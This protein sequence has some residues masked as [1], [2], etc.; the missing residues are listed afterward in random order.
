MENRIEAL[1]K[2]DSF[3]FDFM[4]NNSVTHCDNCK[5]CDEVNELV[6]SEPWLKFFCYQFVRNVQTL[7]EIISFRH[8][9]RERRCNT[10]NYW[11]HDRVTNF[12]N[13]SNIN[14]K[15]VD[16]ISELLKVWEHMKSSKYE[17]ES[18]ICELQKS[19]QSKNLEE[20]KRKK[21]M[22]DYC[23]NYNTLKGFLTKPYHNNCNIYYDYLKESVHEFSK[24]AKVHNAQCSSINN[25]LSFCNKYDPEDLL[26]NSKCKVVEIS[27]DKK[28]YIQ[29]E[30]CE[31]SKVEAVS[32]AIS[33][34]EEV[35]ISEFTFSDNR[36]IILI[37]LSLW[38]VFLTFLFLYKITPFRSWISNKIGKRKIIRDHFNEQSD[39]ETLN[40]DYECMDK[41]MQNAGYNISYNTDWNS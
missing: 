36:A 16:I 11:I 7:Y 8:D 9:L 3:K 22:F 25:C 37:L 27:K 17:K 5:L 29:K 40:A 34:T 31:A 20:M 18:Y 1:K 39:D 19:E 38:G 32:Q 30:E 15:K 14:V 24:I 4:L 28:E 33:K 2:L 35:K 23:E 10:L 21:I 6:K 12:Y 26:N 13:T 41:N